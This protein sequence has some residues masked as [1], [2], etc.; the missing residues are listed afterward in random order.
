MRNS[1]FLFFGC[2]CLMQ[3]AFL[4]AAL[5]APA[6]VRENGKVYRFQANWAVSCHPVDGRYASLAFP[7]DRYFCSKEEADAA[8]R[9]A[10]VRVFVI[11]DQVAP[12]GTVQSIRWSRERPESGEWFQAWLSWAN[13]R[14]PGYFIDFIFPF[15]YYYLAIPDA[16]PDFPEQYAMTREE[17]ANSWLEV[18]LYK[19]RVVPLRLLLNGIPAEDFIRQRKS[20]GAANG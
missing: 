5:L 13:F 10:H 15:R 1:R 8:D 7:L 4:C 18:S 16:E 6:T 19:G 2:F 12:D 9:D 20:N 11:L 14:E 3:L 17:Q